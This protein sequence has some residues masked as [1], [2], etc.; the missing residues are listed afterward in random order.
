M[1]KQQLDIC[2]TCM[3]GAIYR[4]PGTAAFISVVQFP[5]GEYAPIYCKSEPEHLFDRMKSNGICLWHEPKTE[6]EE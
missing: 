2:L 4:F 6:G 1:G 5:N 3:Y